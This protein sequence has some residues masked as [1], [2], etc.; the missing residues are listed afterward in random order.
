MLKKIPV[1]LLT[2]VSIVEA[3]A[4][5]SGDLRETFLSECTEQ[6]YRE[7]VRDGKL[8]SAAALTIVGYV[9]KECLKRLDE[10]WRHLVI[11]ND[12]YQNGNL[13]DAQYRAQINS[14]LDVETP[15]SFSTSKLSQQQMRNV[16]GKTSE[17]E[18][19][20]SVRGFT[21]ISSD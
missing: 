3:A 19:I 21:T 15:D 8:V 20:E 17:A 7:R 16:R 5:S 1:V 6:V 14:Q 9:P 2:T 11:E 18:L 4:V 10:V 12:N 13:T